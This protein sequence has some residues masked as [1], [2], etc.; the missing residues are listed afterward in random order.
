MHAVRGVDLEI[1]QGEIVAFLGP[2]GAGKTTTIDMVLGLSR[3]TRGTVEVLGMQPRQ[4]IARGLVVRGDADRWPAQGPHRAG[5]RRSTPPACSP[6]PSRSTTCSRSAGITDIAD[7]KVGKCSGGE[8]Q[9]LRFAMALLSDPALLLL[10]EPT[11]GMDVE[12]RRAFWSAIREDAAAGPHGAVRDPLPRGG[13]PVRRPDRADAARAGSSP[14][15]AA[16]EIK[17]LAAGRTVRATLD[18]RRTRRAVPARRRRRRSRS[19]ASRSCV[20]AKDTDP[21]ARYLLTET[22]ARD[23]EITSRGL[24]DAF[25]SLTG[26]SDRDDDTEPRPPKEPS[27][28]APARSTRRTR[29]VPPLGG[30]NPTL[31]RHRAGADAA[32]PPHDRLHAGLPRRRCSSSSAPAPAGTETRRPR[33]RRGLHHGLDGAVRR[34]ADRRGRR[35]PGSRS[36]GRSA[37]RASCG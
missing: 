2:N 18:R 37:G 31:L 26:D 22:D 11:T 36:S 3:P 12:G 17:A 15:A 19:A 9:R 27:D 29:R 35:A 5:D 4:A 20:H 14:T 24:E 10:D 21:V 8:Q 23:L 7:R 16:R 1:Q 28:D 33:Q 13:R 32:Q 30:F 6:T 25:L 34:R